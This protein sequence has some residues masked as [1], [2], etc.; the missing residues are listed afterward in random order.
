[1]NKDGG[2]PNWASAARMTWLGLSLSWSEPQRG[3]RCGIRDSHVRQSLQS[4]GRAEAYR[5]SRRISVFCI[6]TFFFFILILSFR[7]LFSLLARQALR[8]QAGQ[9]FMCFVAF[10]LPAAACMARKGLWGVEGGTDYRAARQPDRGATCEGRC[11][12]TEDSR[13]VPGSS[14]RDSSRAGLAACLAWPSSG[15]RHQRRRWLVVADLCAQG[16]GCGFTGWSHRLPLV[17]SC[18]DGPG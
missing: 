13:R 17:P 16:L 3:H 4:Q 15:R 1:M 8:F 7:V 12:T 5:G 2:G 18:A 14:K 9:R 10:S 6:L 11:R